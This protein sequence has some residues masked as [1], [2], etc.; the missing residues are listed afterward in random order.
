M[1]NK[2]ISR[3]LRMLSS[4]MEL[5]D[6][7]PFKI[8]SITNA[9][10]QVDRAASRIAEMTEA[11]ILS[12][13]GIGKSMAAKIYTLLTTGMDP[14]MDEMLEKTPAGIVEILQIKGI[15]PKKVRTL[16][17]ELEIESTGEL[18]YAC[19]ENR[20]VEL[21]G[22]G[23]KTQD[24]IR[25][26]LEFSLLN[27]GKLHFA[28]A[29]AATRETIKLL[30]EKFLECRFEVTGELRRQNETI[31]HS[32][33]LCISNETVDFTNHNNENLQFSTYGDFSLLETSAGYRFRIYH[34][35]PEQAN[36]LQFSLTGPSTHVKELNVEAG[37]YNSEVE[38]YRAAGKEFISPV[39]RD[40]PLIEA[41]ELAKNTAVNE[42]DIKGILHCH[43]TWSDGADTLEQMAIS[44]QALGKE[45]FGICDHSKSAFYANGLSIERVLA[46]HAEIDKLNQKFDNFKIFKGIE[47]DILS[48]GS[49]DY[50]DE[51][52][53]TFD[54]IV[55]SVHSVLRMDEERATSRL[56]KAV[57]NPYTTILG[58]PSTRLLLSRKGFPI[59][60]PKLIDAC[61][62]N[63]VSIEL[64]AHPYRLDI[65]WRL[66]PQCVEKGV[67]IAINPDSHRKEGLS[68]IRYGVLVAQ[69]AGLRA[70]DV[71]NN[72]SLQEFS[73]F[74]NK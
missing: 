7:N 11:E 9:S 36:W 51:I 49:L 24:S 17:K 71:L 22:F 38:I 1:T 72:L 20:L 43:S 70:N 61:A 3:A 52:L 50:P 31:D 21:K 33:I 60:Y 45:Y 58:H 34:S 4:L 35:K 54:F 73:E 27:A 41:S 10:F 18:L 12:I 66:I 13:P 19:N 74:I 67:K 23:A 42:G 53:A 44:T 8:K 68:D 62:A 65:D 64:N 6:E 59:N 55:A 63:G 29:E 46:Q 69:K 26:S 28:E 15:G 39:L 14:E 47:S 57:E 32:D 5:H 16:W 40:W 25:Q 37:F 48:D 2:E 56:I 30:E